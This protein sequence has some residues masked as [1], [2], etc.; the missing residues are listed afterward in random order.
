MRPAVNKKTYAGGRKKLCGRVLK[1]QSAK[2]GGC[3]K[4]NLRGQQ[5]K[6]L[7]GRVLKKQSAKT[8]GCLKKKPSQP[9]GEKTMRPGA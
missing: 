9:A 7:C 1:K 4:R 5:A 2:T 3:L 6:K 8:G